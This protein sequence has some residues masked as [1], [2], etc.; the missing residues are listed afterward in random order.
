LW[1]LE[2]SCSKTW[3]YYKRLKNKTHS[4]KINIVAHS[5]GGL[6]AR[7]YLANDPL[8]DVE[9]L[10]MIGTPNQGS[11]IANWAKMLPADMAP[12]FG[13]FLSHLLYMT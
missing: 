4:D 8:N 9:K 11:P 5:K 2:N 7:M 13:E 12:L 10:I 1:K 6:D 3:C